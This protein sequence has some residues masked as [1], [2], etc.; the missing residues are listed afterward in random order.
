MG[1][2]LIVGKRCRSRISPRR[3]AARYFNPA[4]VTTQRF[5]GQKFVRA[6]VWSVM[7]CNNN[8]HFTG[9]ILNSNSDIFQR[10]GEIEKNSYQTLKIDS[11]S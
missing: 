5:N 10:A 9:L 2:S 1:K 8:C 11:A 6:E 3:N 7:Y 4:F